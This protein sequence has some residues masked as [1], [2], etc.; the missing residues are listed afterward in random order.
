ME[1]LYP[2]MSVHGLYD[3]NSRE[4]QATTIYIMN[5]QHACKSIEKSEGRQ[6]ERINFTHFIVSNYE[7]DSKS[8][9]L[10]YI[11]LFVYVLPKR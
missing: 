1:V 8:Y 4:P 6:K 2:I 5:E 9:M 10:E 11:F 3:I 7:I